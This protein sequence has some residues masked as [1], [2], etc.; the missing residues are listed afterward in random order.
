M[1]RPKTIPHIV[2]PHHA[3]GRLCECE[4]LGNG[5][6]CKGEKTLWYIHSHLS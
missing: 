1:Q 2:N 4:F 5:D 3:S 6:V